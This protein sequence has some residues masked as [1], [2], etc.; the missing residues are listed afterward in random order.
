LY[1]SLDTAVPQQFFASSMVLT[2]LIRGLLGLDV[3]APA[4][5][6]VVAPHLPPEWDSVRV[7]NVPVGRDRVDVSIHRTSQRIVADFSRH[8]AD[9]ERA[10]LDIVFS[11]ALPLGA[12]SSVPTEKTAGDVHATVRGVLRDRLTLD[13]PYSGG[14]SI[15]PPVMPAVI[16]ARSAAPRVLSERLVDGKYVVAL[17]G[18]AGRTYRFRLRAWGKVDR[19]VDVTFPST[20]ANE[21]GYSSRTI[22]FTSD[23]GRP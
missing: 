22:S 3:D 8:F 20:G 16:G 17:E 19:E 1:K 23:G 18:L 9:V 21:D 11:P 7:E 5:R 12:S 2:P 10:P 15:I 6:M 13:V 14:S 4:H